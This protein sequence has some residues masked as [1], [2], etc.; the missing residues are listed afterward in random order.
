MHVTCPDEYI[1]EEIA[2]KLVEARLAACV[3]TIPGSADLRPTLAFKLHIW[4]TE[5]CLICM[6]FTHEPL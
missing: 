6:S 5:L 2:E 3:Q 4:K 1:A